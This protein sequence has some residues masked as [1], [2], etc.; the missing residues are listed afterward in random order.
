MEEEDIC[1]SDA[2]DSAFF[3]SA[4]SRQMVAPARPACCP[5]E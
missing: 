1:G 5:R 2:A 3:L 4:G